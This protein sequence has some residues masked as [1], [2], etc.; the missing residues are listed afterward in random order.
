[1]RDPGVAACA[2]ASVG[3]TVDDVG[4]APAVRDLSLRRRRSKFPW[5][6]AVYH[7]DAERL[8]EFPP[9]SGPSAAVG[10]AERDAFGDR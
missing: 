5:L 7:A 3:L 6:Y 4:R 2:C 1:M 10:V 9:S 8:D